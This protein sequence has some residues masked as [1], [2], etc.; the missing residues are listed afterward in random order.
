M[1]IFS[2]ELAVKLPFEDQQLIPLRKTAGELY[3]EQETAGDRERKARELKP[4]RRQQTKSLKDVRGNCFILQ[5]CARK[6]TR[7]VVHRTHN[8]IK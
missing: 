8:V 2:A 3:A 5:Y 6:F 1:V 7:H 4:R